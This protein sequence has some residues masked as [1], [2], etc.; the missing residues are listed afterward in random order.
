MARWQPDASERLQRAAMELFLDRGYDAVT[1]VEIADRAGL[2][3]RSFFNHFADKR[4]VLFA[5]APAFQA[6]VL[7][8]LADGEAG[9]DPVAAAVR[10]L[11]RGGLGLA[12]YAD[13]AQARRD[14]IA[15]SLDLQERDLIKM[16]SLAAAIAGGLREQGTAPRSATFAAQSAVAVFAAAYDD[17]AQDPAA[18]LASLMQRSLQEFRRAVAER[19]VDARDAPA[20][21]AP[22]Q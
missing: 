5:G 20:H 7:E 22:V 16:A 11:T 21:G 1:V 3:K 10:A 4:E 19:T 8:H 12:S 18:D 13:T 9:S 2:T 17:W 15:S 6:G 14:L